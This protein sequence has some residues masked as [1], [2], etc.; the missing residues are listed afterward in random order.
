MPIRLLTLGVSF[1]M[2]A[3]YLAHAS[4]PEQIPPRA[5]FAS[6]P[7]QLGDWTGRSAP[8]FGRDVI[9]A[10][11][12]D[13]YVNRYYTTGNRLAHVYIGYYSSQRQGSSIHSP[14]N[15]LPGAGWVAVESGRRMLATAGGPAAVNRLIVQKGLDRQLVLYWYESHGRT[16]ASEYWS[17]IYL[18]LD[19]IRLGRSDAALVRIIAPIDGSLP[20]GEALAD[21]SAIDLAE[22][23]F[24]ALGRYLPS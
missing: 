6:F 24:P 8:E 9:D 4:R 3:A 20:N 10:L 1:L 19:S 21:R 13:E 22:T 11:G 14:M 12:V 15:C 16:I 2:T 23:M 18:V 7:A 5:P 17:K